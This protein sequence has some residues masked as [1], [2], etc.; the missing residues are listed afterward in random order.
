M[1]I[2][3]NKKIEVIMAKDNLEERWYILQP[4]CY[5][6]IEMF[7]KDI[8]DHNEMKLIQSDLMRFEIGICL[9]P[10]VTG[11]KIL[12]ERIKHIRKGIESDIGISI[13]LI[14]ISENSSLKPFEY[15]FSIRMKRL[16][17]FEIKANKLLSLENNKVKQK[18]VGKIIKE[19]TFGIPA[20]WIGK[21]KL[22]EA[23]DKGYTIV[24][25]PAII[26]TSLNNLI[27]ENIVEI[28]T[29]DMSKNILENVL[30]NNKLLV[31]DCLSK[32]EPI[33]IKNFLAMILEK[34]KSLLNIDKILELI[35]FYSEDKNNMEKIVKK[36]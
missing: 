15:S 22:Q 2:L 7:K 16:M 20:I 18:I 17:K 13:P 5:E 19:P 21:N 8:Q 28:F 29:Y 32:F 26:C 3:K 14:R 36:S 31:K 10:L 30:K 6:A 23:I 4:V 9:I 11:E 35:L 24:D 25:T 34:K 27:R 33:E 1:N 12:L